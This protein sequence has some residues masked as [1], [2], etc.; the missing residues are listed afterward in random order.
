MSKAKETKNKL[1]SKIEA[2]KKINDDPQGTV[3]SLYDSYLS[4]LPSTDQ[5]FGKKLDDF[6]EK[7][8]K[9]KEN[10]KDIFAELV[11]I[12]EGFLGL[13]KKVAPND[14]LFSKGRL[15]QHAISATKKTLESSK[16]VVL[17]S[18]KKVFFAADGICGTDT[19][20]GVDS[21]KL[22]PKEFDF[23]NILT[24]SPTSTVGQIV[25]EKT[26]S[27][28]KEQ[29]NR[30][31][32]SS[33][34]DPNGYTFN[35]N[36]N[37]TLFQMVWSDSTQE[38]NVTGLTQGGG[39]GDPK[40][41]SFLNEYYSNIE[42]PDID[43]IVKT[44][45]LMT[46]QG[47]GSESTLFNQSLN[48]VNRLIKKLCAVC[49]TPTN[50]NN[51][52]S[53][54]AVD[55][56]DENDEDIESY[57]NFDD[58]E[59][60]DLD[61]EDAR[62]RKVLKFTDCNNFE[63]PVNTSMLEDFVFLSS[64]K[65][66]NELVNSTIS[67]TATDAYLQSDSSIPEINFNLNLLNLFI[68]NLPKAL[69]MS[70]LSPKIFLPIIIIYKVLK[71]LANQTIDVLSTMKNLSKL[72][73][74]VVKEIFWKFITEF[75]KLV[76]VDLLAFVLKLVKKIL[77]NKYKRYVVIITAL[78]ALLIKI[79]QDGLDNC[80]DLFNVILSTIQGALSTKAILNVPGILLGLSDKLPG[81]SQDR[82]Y[83]N[84][85]ER[86]QKA[87]IDL[88]PIYGEGNDIPAMI[89]S[90]IDGNTEELDVNSFVSVSNK[91]IIIPTPIGPVIIPP[92]ILNSSGKLM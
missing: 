66:L 23:L 45:M 73:Y 5:L 14:K 55:L 89:K 17:S 35:S 41:E 51:I 28:N 4:D 81:Y 62:F 43:H 10:N 72:F 64:K 1:K 3:D 25:Y 84:I 29:V 42:F 2:I 31:L 34:T 61:D 21:I 56:F 65:N 39:V 37:N 85:S 12:T 48:D 70:V 47:D 32:Y 13:N 40:V 78:I 24:V 83:L 90:I 50:R 16:D 11:D 59:G 86:L 67:R 38:F 15:K 82:A 88:S 54:N 19:T 6:L 49:G 74:G 46:L 77:K 69:L 9:K 76:K 75:W 71:S 79:L 36:N 44:S 18:V 63:I 7:R 87:G 27:K 57:F 33:F 52:Q 60:I 92:G 53:Q 68:L 22:K 8:R 30:E 26:P 20:I 91:E 58:V 80:Y